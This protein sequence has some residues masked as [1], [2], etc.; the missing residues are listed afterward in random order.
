MINSFFATITI[1]YIILALGIQKCKA[2]FHFEKIDIFYSILLCRARE[3]ACVLAQLE[4]EKGREQQQ[5]QNQSAFLKE[6]FS[7]FPS[8]FSKADQYAKLFIRTVEA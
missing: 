3:L 8:F 4:N 6:S 2:R 1:S 5:Q 7:H